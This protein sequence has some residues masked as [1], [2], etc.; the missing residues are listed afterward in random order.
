ML[1]RETSFLWRPIPTFEARRSSRP[2]NLWPEV[3]EEK[4]PTSGT[5]SAGVPSPREC[6]RGIRRRR[7]AVSSSSDWSSES[8]EFALESTGRWRVRC[9]STGN[10]PESLNRLIPI[11]IR[12]RRWKS[13]QRRR[14]TER[15]APVKDKTIV[16]ILKFVRGY[17]SCREIVISKTYL[18]TTRLAGYLE[19]WNAQLSD[20]NERFQI[21]KLLPAKVLCWEQGYRGSCRAPNVAATS[22]G[23]VQPEIRKSSIFFARLISVIKYW[24]LAE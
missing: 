14:R 7:K 9:S 22:S 17:S 23:I 21:T 5:R 4:R 13:L 12:R 10:R 18:T 1:S 24:V 2:R 19:T 11:S 8:K 3:S 15:L 20:K 6:L 16:K